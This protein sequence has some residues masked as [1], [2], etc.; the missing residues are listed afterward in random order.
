MLRGWS[1]QRLI[2]C[3]TE[4]LVQQQDICCVVLHFEWRSPERTTSECKV[5]RPVVDFDLAVAQ[6]NSSDTCGEPSLRPNLDAVTAGRPLGV[7]VAESLDD[8]PPRWFS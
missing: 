7:R 2:C 5:P 6:P 1:G 8:A 3:P 4:A